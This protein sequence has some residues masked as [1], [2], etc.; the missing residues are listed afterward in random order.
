MVHRTLNKWATDRNL[1]AAAILPITY[2]FANMNI[3]IFMVLQNFIMLNLGAT[4]YSFAVKATAAALI[5]LL[6]ARFV[7]RGGK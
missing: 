1:L 4:G 7:V 5:T 2:I 6:F 3:V